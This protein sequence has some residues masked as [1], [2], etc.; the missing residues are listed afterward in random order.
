M[1][2]QNFLRKCHIFTILILTVSFFTDSFALENE[3]SA[4]ESGLR[5]FLENRIKHRH[6]PR[7]YPLPHPN[8]N[9]RTALFALPRVWNNLSAEFKQ[10]YNEAL[11]IPSSFQV[12]ESPGGFFEIYFSSD[13]NDSHCV[14]KTDNY[15]YSKQNWSLKTD[16]PNG[17]P[18]YIDE[19][20]W[21]LDSTY[22]AE[23]IGFEFKEPFP[24][25]K[26]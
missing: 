20:G 12:F 21:A 11:N 17:V 4:L 6:S 9:I 23:I 18:D 19:V 1:N 7:Y 14:D 16:T 26:Y 10:L 13:T 24:Y 3:I 8:Q 15:G 5:P 22:S 2:Y 25:K